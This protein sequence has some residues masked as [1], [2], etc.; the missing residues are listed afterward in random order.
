MLDFSKD[1]GFSIPWSPI[2]FI[3]AISNISR[4]EWLYDEIN[5]RVVYI[6]PFKIGLIQNGYHSGSVGILNRKG[7]LPAEKL[8]MQSLYDWVET[9]GVQK[10]F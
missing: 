5:H 7:I 6:E 3:E 8:K 1:I 10:R 4:E 2:R 9:D